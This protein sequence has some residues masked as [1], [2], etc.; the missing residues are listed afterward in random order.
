[1]LQTTAIPGRSRFVVLLALVVALALGLVS[2]LVAPPA[3]AATW[4]LTASG[5]GT[6]TA[7]TEKTLTVSYLRS[8]KPVRGAAV[9]LQR[10]KG[11]SWVDVRSVR[12][13]TKGRAS[14]TVK[15]TSSTSY[16][17]RTSQARSGTVTV[18][19]VPVRF[20]IS[21]SGS[22]HGVGLAQWGAY[23]QARSGRTA[24]QIL[25]YYYP[26]TTVSTANDPRTTLDVQVLGPPSDSRTTTVLAV[27]SGS[28][29]LTDP[30]NTVVASGVAAEKVTVGV[31]SGGVTAKV[32][33]GGATVR[34]VT[35]RSSL[36]Y[37]W[38]GTRYFQPTATE[39]PVATVA[40]AQGT[41]RNGRLVVTKR[42]NRPNVVNEVIINTEYLYGL[43]EMPSGWGASTNGGAAALQAQAVA[44]RNYAI[45]EKV[46]GLKPECGCHVYDDTR[47]Q[48]YTGWTKQ[49]GSWGG[50]WV[51]AVNATI[52]AGDRTVTVLR[53]AE[54]GF[55]ETPYFASTGGA[56]GRRGTAT[57][58]EVFGTTALPYLKHVGD[59]YS[60]QAP[61]NPYVGWSDSITQAKARS[62][63]G[64]PSV[65]SIAV[66]SR[67]SSGQVRTLT[68]TSATGTKVS[69]TRTADGWRTTL[70]VRASWVGSLAGRNT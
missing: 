39:K 66:T 62:I 5:G 13:G 12:T 68:A 8:G 36:T 54:G 28:W 34:T 1:M 4:T 48:H 70:G 35:A 57:N 26:G 53:D 64:L 58:A 38:S 15:P 61:K 20:A 27:D 50:T 2:V 44:A 7:A 43:D 67:W 37:E 25:G 69:R 60:A 6:T 22:G 18:L 49:G 55:A 41:Y 56:G 10:K 52:Q 17:F 29:R 14:T 16:R 9:T 59:P 11:S 46:K 24:A 32:T 19:V 33:K 40:G 31:T 63:F 23:Q 45:V 51:A 3:Q 30:E 47:S 21:G 42:S 65:R